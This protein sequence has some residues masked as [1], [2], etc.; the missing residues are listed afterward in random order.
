MFETFKKA[1]ALKNT[2]RANTIIFS[3]KQIPF[4]GK[5]LPNA[6]YKSQGL[7]LFAMI[8]SVIFEFLTVFF[9]KPFYIFFLVYLPASL[10][11]GATDSIM[12]HIF[13]LLTMVGTAAN[14]NL[15]NPTKD[16]FYA[17][18][19]MRMNARKYALVDYGYFLLKGF[20]GM[21]PAILICG[22]FA[23]IPLYICILMSLFYITA[24]VSYSGFLLYKSQRTG[25]I[26]NENKPTP[27]IYVAIII[28]GALAY[29][30]PFIGIMMNKWMF[31]GIF[32]I[33]AITFIFA[34]RYIITFKKFKQVYLTLLNRDNIIFSMQKFVADTNKVSYT[35][36]IDSSA[37]GDEKKEGYG[38]FHD[39]F[40]RRHRKLLLKSAKNFSLVIGAILIVLII[41]V[42]L[43]SKVSAVANEGMLAALPF[44]L[45][46]MYFINRGQSVTAA[47]FMNCDHSMLT[48]RFYRQPK[49]ILDLFTRRLKTLIMINLLP[50]G[51]M[52]VGMPLVL[53]LSGGTDNPLNYAVLFVSIIS[54]SIFF[55]VHH[56]TIYY[57]LQPYNAEIQMKSV[58]YNI[59][60]YVTYFFAFIPT[61]LADNFSNLLFGSF[62]IIF[63]IVYVAISLFL[64]YK[65]APRTFKIR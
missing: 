51:I 58:S 41:G 38:Y 56:L 55:S 34:A 24:K 47:M 59:V 45:F 32:A 5:L 18:A 12:L 62:V 23:K 27:M 30:L 1:F 49:A 31:L 42:E 52:A 22:H 37:V 61:Q 11:K 36:T 17:I 40:V 63:T 21:M 48:Y 39:I 16:K 44:L 9:N 15:F 2:Y 7:K 57:L 35:K 29:G 60:S 50:A 43:N 54:M 19:L 8:I 6:M 13:V 14:S 33:S 28:F 25:K 65:Y 20:V 10:Y 3:L 64:A 26:Y 53:Y 46:V 4:I